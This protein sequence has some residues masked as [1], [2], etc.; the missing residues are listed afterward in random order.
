MDQKYTEARKFLCRYL[1]DEA[2]EKG[3]THQAIAD[4]TGFAKN[5]VTR[6]LSGRYSPSLDNFI[7]LADAI[8]V[9]FFI[10]D[11]DA[12]GDLVDMMKKRWGEI[13]TN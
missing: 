3:I 11:K 10:I 5:N 7:K 2:K 13:H 8:G 4:R 6:M 1:A 9:Y 12:E